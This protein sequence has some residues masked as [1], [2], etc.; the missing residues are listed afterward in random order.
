MIIICKKQTTRA[1][2]C[3]IAYGQKFIHSD[4]SQKAE[5]LNDQ[6][7]SVYT[8]E[9]HK[10]FPDK[11]KSTIPTMK[12]INIHFVHANGVLKLLKNLKVHKATGP[13]NI[14]SR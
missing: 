6:F 3:A 12:K 1:L 9:D 10:N 13:D 7:Q 2:R 14:P 8:A 11:G 4:S 5:I